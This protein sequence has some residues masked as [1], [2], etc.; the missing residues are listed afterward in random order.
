MTQHSWLFPSGSIKNI[1][2]NNGNIETFKDTP[3]K[4]LGREICQNSLDAHANKSEPVVIDFA[5]FSLETERFPDIEAFRFAINQGQRFWKTQN[6]PKADKF[7]TKAKSVIGKTSITCLRI[8]DHNTVGLGGSDRLDDTKAPW[9]ALVLSEGASSKD[10]AEGGSFGIGKFA[11]YANSSLRTVFFSTVDSEKKQASQGISYLASFVDANGAKTFGDGYCGDGTVPVYEKL[12]LDPSFVRKD[13]ETGTDIFI[14]GFN[15]D[16]DWK[17]K[18]IASVLDGFM[19]AI[20]QGML[21]V[22]VEDV[23]I[24]KTTLDDVI[25]NYHSFCDEYALDYYAVLRSDM[26]WI[27][28]DDYKETG[29]LRIKL[30]V[31]PGLQ[32]RVAMIRKTGMKIIDRSRINNQV[33]FA[34]IMYIEGEK[35]NKFLVSLENPAHTKWLPERCEE[36]PR[37]ASKYL[38]GLGDILRDELQK[39]IADQFGG[40]V[41]PALGNLLQSLGGSEGKEKQADALLDEPLEL[42]TTKKDIVPQR[43]IPSRI[44][45]TGEEGEPSG[46]EGGKDHG[47]DGHVGDGPGY[48][49]GE[50]GRG[51]QGDS[52][53]KG[54]KDGPDA[55]GRTAV[56]MIKLL[57]RRPIV[58]DPAQGLYS[59]VIVPSQSAKN[60]S[61]DIELSGEDYSYKPDVLH[62][63]VVDQPDVEI[64]G[65]KVN[66]AVLTQGEKTTLELQIDA[67]DLVAFEVKCYEITAK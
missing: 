58:R 1:G 61:I 62:L 23:T 33:P 56:R 54:L 20:D 17:E 6:N 37:K 40:E 55:G 24:S 32:R 27:T 66:N 2:I 53:N 9:T 19:F 41:T 34:G 60:A 4:S 28:I 38:A 45:T 48:G 59:F 5:S 18:L 3:I 11:A 8:S 31:Q 16:N 36:S 51:S 21:V 65:S 25:E 46:D 10:G 26:P 15:T 49:S 35:A 47:E 13:N 64:V 39:L 43:A 63:S 14:C 7:Y 44:D 30:L 67:T 42:K 12:S 29:K 57:S 52:D 50:T 22:N